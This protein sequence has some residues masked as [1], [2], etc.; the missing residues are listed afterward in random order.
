MSNRFASFIEKFYLKEKIRPSLMALYLNRVVQAACFGFFSIF[1]PIF[2]YQKFNNSLE[3]VLI[4]FILSYATYALTVV[5]G[6]KIMSRIGLRNS[7]VISVVF[8]IGF[9]SA[10][11]F[12]QATIGYL[13]FLVILKNLF[14]NFYWV[15]FHTEFAEFTDRRHRG[16]EVGFFYAL[17]SV[18]KVGV[19]V[20]GGFIIARYGFDNL[21][22]LVIILAVISIIPLF[23]TQKVK[24]KFSW[25]YFK[26][27]KKLFSKGCRR[28]VLAFFAD[29][30]QDVIGLV[31]WPIYIFI[32]LDEKYSSVGIVTSL[33][34]LTVLVLYLVLGNFS[35]RFSK[36]KLLRYSSF[37][38]ALGWVFKA[39]VY[40]AGHIFIAGTYH[41]FSKAVMRT[42]FDALRY[43]KAA[44]RGHYVD[45]YTVLREIAICSGRALMLILIFVIIQFTDIRIAFYVAAFA[46]LFVSV[47]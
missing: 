30:M 19:P 44:D 24:E 13:I 35:D 34:I 20:T 41:D 29:G 36:H 14:R 4:Y 18:L 11:Y 6:A 3:I 40:S 27:I 39:L 21:F 23:L 22:I 37:F 42:P 31:I 8:L 33:I 26:T 2:L 10:Y 46:S 5:F 9:F 12:F 7:M 25:S 15:P 16:R 47:L 45:E 1:I 28:W 17:W 32:L 38:Y 43:E